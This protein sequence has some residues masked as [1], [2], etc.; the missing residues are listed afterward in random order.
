MIAFLAMLPIRLR[1]LSELSL[2]KSALVSATQ[3]KVALS[4]DMTKNG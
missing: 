2:G 1:S 4:G 3:I